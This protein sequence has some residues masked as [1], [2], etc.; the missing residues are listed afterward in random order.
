MELGCLGGISVDAS[1][2][3]ERSSC[4]NKFAEI[5]G[6]MPLKTINFRADPLLYKDEII[7]NQ[8][9]KQRFRD[10]GEL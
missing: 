4:I 9:I 3:V 8:S 2:V 5:Y 7:D 1:H 6:Y 10:M